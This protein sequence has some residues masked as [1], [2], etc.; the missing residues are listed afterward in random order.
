[1]QQLDFVGRRKLE[2]R[3][4]S[5]PRLANNR[6]ALVRP[7]A[8]ATCDLDPAIIDGVVRVVWPTEMMAVLPRWLGQ[9]RRC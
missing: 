3:D 9:Q 2:W 5:P 7:F 8:V 4:V 6:E 1:V